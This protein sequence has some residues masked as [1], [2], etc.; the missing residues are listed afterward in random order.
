MSNHVNESCWCQP[1]PKRVEMAKSSF[2]LNHRSKGIVVCLCAVSVLIVLLWIVFSVLAKESQATI[3]SDVHQDS[4]S[5]P[6]MV[7]NDLEPTTTTSILPL[8]SLA[9]SWLASVVNGKQTVQYA[10]ALV[11]ILAV[12]VAAWCVVVYVIIPMLSHFSLIEPS[13]PTTNDPEKNASNTTPTTDN[14]TPQEEM[15]E[16]MKL[17]YIFLGLS[18]GVALLILALVVYRRANPPAQPPQNIPND[19]VSQFFDILKTHDGAVYGWNFQKQGRMESVKAKVCNL[20]VLSQCLS[21]T[22]DPPTGKTVYKLTISNGK[23]EHNYNVWSE[24][25]EFNNDTM[26]ILAIYKQA[27]ELVKGNFI[28]TSE[29]LNK[30]L[31]WESDELAFFSSAANA[32]RVKITRLDELN[33]ETLIQDWDEHFQNGLAAIRT[34]H[35]LPVNPNVGNAIPLNNTT[36][37]GDSDTGS[38][39]ENKDKSENGDDVGSEGE[40]GN[41]NPDG[42]IELMD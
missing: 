33:L 2:Y 15:S 28:L 35:K 11:T 22:N 17:L 29:L 37:G 9:V 21:P 5:P 23:E 20:S 13:T 34:A 16:G 26:L 14:T 12:L 36:D 30:P 24:S 39:S 38:S 10:I 27:S 3:E 25:D 8:V 6:A 4:A 19:N 18:G 1:G 40:S 32:R 31:E 42:E 7:V 41:P